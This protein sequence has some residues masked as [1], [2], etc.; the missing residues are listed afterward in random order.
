[1]DTHVHT[2]GNAHK[3]PLSAGKDV[4]SPRAEARHGREPHNMGKL[5]IEQGSAVRAE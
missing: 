2:Y 1:M 5:G 3:Y 4:E